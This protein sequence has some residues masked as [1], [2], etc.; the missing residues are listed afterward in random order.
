[1]LTNY[2]LHGLL[3]VYFCSLLNYL[4]LDTLVLSFYLILIV[5]CPYLNLDYCC[6]SHHRIDPLLNLDA[7][8]FIKFY[9][10]GFCFKN[11]FCSKFFQDLLR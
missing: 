2:L 4:A 3:L 1:V 8:I 6:L 5:Y 10:Q 7:L 9:L 11:L